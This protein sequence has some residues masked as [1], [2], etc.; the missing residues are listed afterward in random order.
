M[1]GGIMTPSKS[2]QWQGVLQRFDSFVKTVIHN[3]KVNFYIAEKR[4]RKEEILFCELDANQVEAFTDIFAETELQ[5]LF[6]KFEVMSTVVT[7]QNSLLYEAL[8]TLDKLHRDIILMTFWLD[9]NDR[10]IAEKLNYKTRTVNYIRNSAY[11]K[12]AEI[13]GGKM[14]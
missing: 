5:F 14:I 1:G 7:V 8:S 6:D 4:Q 2:M 13:I 11:K 3:E 12:L 9:M 10:E